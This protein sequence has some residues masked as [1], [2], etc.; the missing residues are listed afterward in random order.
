MK[1]LIVGLAEE[2]NR[3]CPEATKMETYRVSDMLK[4]KWLFV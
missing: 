1:G 4:Y 2:L 3:F